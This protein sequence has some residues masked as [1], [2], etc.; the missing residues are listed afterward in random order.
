MHF[1]EVNPTPKAGGKW[2]T[3]EITA[4]NRQ[5]TVTLNGKKTSEL[6]N[7]L[8]TEGPIAVQHGAGVIKFRKIELRPL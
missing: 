1:A 8:F 7:T 2:N 6:R 4:K 3:M 5:I